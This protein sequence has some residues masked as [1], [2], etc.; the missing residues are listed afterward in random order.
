MSDSNFLN[1]KDCINY[2]KID[3]LFYFKYEFTVINNNIWPLIII[4][5]FSSLEVYIFIKILLFGE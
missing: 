5:L 2:N 3:L 4:S 1:S